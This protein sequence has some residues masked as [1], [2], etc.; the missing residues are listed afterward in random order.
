MPK[1]NKCVV[2][3][4]QK[5]LKEV[6]E[7]DKSTPGESSTILNSNN[8]KYSLKWK[9]FCTFMGMEGDLAC[10]MLTSRD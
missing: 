1:L 2:R 3:P 4:F 8:I 7:L 9:L 5:H 6:A 10:A